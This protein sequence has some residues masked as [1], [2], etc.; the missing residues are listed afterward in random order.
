[1][2][3][4]GTI[5][6]GEGSRRACT[7]TIAAP[8]RENPALRPCIALFINTSVCVLRTPKGRNFIDRLRL[9]KVAV[10]RSSCAMLRGQL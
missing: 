1:M 10:R 8:H 4:D 2:C 9:D 5:N 3:K 6:K 7:D